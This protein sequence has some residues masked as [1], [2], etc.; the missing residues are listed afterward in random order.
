MLAISSS[1]IGSLELGKRRSLRRVSS[2]VKLVEH[3]REVIVNLSLMGCSVADAPVALRPLE[4]LRL[5]EEGLVRREWRD[6]EYSVLALLSTGVAS[7][8]DPM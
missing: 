7:G 3:D 1:G 2:C 6:C 5:S 4:A 8:A